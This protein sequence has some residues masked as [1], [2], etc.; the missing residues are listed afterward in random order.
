[1]PKD[2]I[3]VPQALEKS[4]DFLDGKQISLPWEDGVWKT[5]FSDKPALSL[6]PIFERPDVEHVQ[7]EAAP[8]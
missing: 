2:I 5:I 7:Q 4:W 6:Q 8:P 1:M 3:P